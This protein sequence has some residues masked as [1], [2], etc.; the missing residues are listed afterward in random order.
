M[1]NNKLTF[2]GRAIQW[3]LRELDLRK[4]SMTTSPC[5]LCGT[6][7]TLALNHTL[8]GVRCLGCMATPVHMSMGIA[9]KQI[10]P[11]YASKTIY[12]ISAHGA[13]FKFLKRMVPDLTCSEYFDGLP[14]GSHRDGVMCQD[15]HALSFA[16]N[17]FDACTCTAL[18]E[19]VADD[20]KGFSEIRRVLRPGGVF[21]FTIPIFDQANT[22]I[23]ATME[24]GQIK[25]L[26]EPEY[27]DDFCLAGL[28][29]ALV[30]RDYGQDVPERLKQAGFSQAW[31]E[32]INEFE[33]FGLRPQVVCAIA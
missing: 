24:N 30:F 13:F 23:R 25:H 6:R 29:G 7:A 33:Q 31:I 4:L 9:L 18:F 27:H 5:P 19:H 14:S 12:E 22:V 16:D 8:A 21:L 28:D 32:T 2:L 1:L 17:S 11:D 10:L 3:G 26:L 15:V 20:I